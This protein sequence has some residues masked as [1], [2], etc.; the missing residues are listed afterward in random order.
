MV[1][2]ED[3]AE[4]GAAAGTRAAFGVVVGVDRRY[5]RGTEV[6]P[7]PVDHETSLVVAVFDDDI[8]V[9]GTQDRSGGDGGGEEEGTRDGQLG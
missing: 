1:H 2:E 9:D 7:Q 5:S 6:I 3:A 8:E 4:T